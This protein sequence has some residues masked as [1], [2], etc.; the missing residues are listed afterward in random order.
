[1]TTLDYLGTLTVM[2]CWCG[3]R[4]AVPEELYDF[5]RRQH[6]D[7]KSVTA[8]Y[9][10]LGHTHVPAG[11]GEAELLRGKLE[12]AEQRR[13]AERELR[14]DTE[15]RLSAQKAATTRAKRRHAAGVCPCCGRTFKQLQRHMTTKHPDYDPTKDNA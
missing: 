8:I 2:T 15:R 7:G 14:E 5:Q 11:K 1:V 10:P 6:R 9:C 12:R 3:V 13:K 4:H